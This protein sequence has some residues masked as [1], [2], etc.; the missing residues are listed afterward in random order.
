MGSEGVPKRVPPT[1]GLIALPSVGPG[2]AVPE[3]TLKPPPP[4]D[5]LLLIV[6]LVFSAGS[7]YGGTLAP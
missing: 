7:G 6:L 1:L 4:D 3:V 2:D 5:E